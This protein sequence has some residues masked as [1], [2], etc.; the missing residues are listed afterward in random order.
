MTAETLKGNNLG[1][2]GPQAN[3]TVAQVQAMLDAHPYQN[4]KA[5][6][7]FDTPTGAAHPA[8]S[9]GF[10][11]TATKSAVGKYIITFTVDMPHEHYTVTTGYADTAGTIQVVSSTS[12]AVGSFQIWIKDGTNSFSDASEFIHFAVHE[13]ST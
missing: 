1:I 8:T 7:K 4:V 12:Y 9:Y 6:G 10:N 13:Y 5:F 11:Y 2:G 3:L